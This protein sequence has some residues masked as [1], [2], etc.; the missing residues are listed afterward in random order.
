MPEPDLIQMGDHLV[1]NSAL[2]VCHLNTRGNFEL[3]KIV[4]QNNVTLLTGA[5]LQQAVVM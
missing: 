5:R 2:V 1:I 3:A 4:L